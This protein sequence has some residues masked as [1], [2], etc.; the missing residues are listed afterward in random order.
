VPYAGT[1]VKWWA[2]VFFAARSIALSPLLFLEFGAI[3]GRRAVRWESGAILLVNSMNAASGGRLQSLLARLTFRPILGRPHERNFGGP[4]SLVEADRMRIHDDGFQILGPLLSRNQCEDIVASASSITV[5]DD[6]GVEF[7][8]LSTWY[9]SAR[10]SDRAFLQIDIDHF[11][12]A[13]IL[14][15]N[16]VLSTVKAFLR[17]DPLIVSVLAW[18][19]RPPR[20]TH[21]ARNDPNGMMFHCDADYLNFVKL[22]VPLT[23]PSLTGGSTEFVRS[24]HMSRRHV[25]GRISE[26]EAR[27][28]GTV[29]SADC[30]AGSGYLCATTGW[31]RAGIPD[32]G[33]RIV[34]QVLFSADLLG[35]RPPQD[36]PIR[37]DEERALTVV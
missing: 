3:R 4:H 15:N 10:A 19:T 26:Q 27:A 5:T 34:A 22:F 24:S 11:L 21:D 8:D 14:S 30:A 2:R 9:H 6:Y 1:T 36:F 23:D 33:I 37:C 16:S 32:G 28:S 18:A 29:L 20:S 7:A 13:F 25:L 12:Q 31:H 17:A 35:R